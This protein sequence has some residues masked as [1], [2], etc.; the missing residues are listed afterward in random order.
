M[1]ILGL[2]PQG[3][4]HQE[5]SEEPCK[6]S[7]CIKQ[8]IPHNLSNNTWQLQNCCLLVNEARSFWPQE[9]H[10]NGKY[11]EMANQSEQ[12][13]LKYFKQSPNSGNTP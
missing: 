11:Q 2:D 5:F 9:Q 6:K 4:V 12:M 3:S 7:M 1:Q 13:I 8:S 10:G